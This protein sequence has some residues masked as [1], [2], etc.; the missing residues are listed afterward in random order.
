MIQANNS[1]SS[2]LTK[3]YHQT[4]AGEDEPEETKEAWSS[5]VFH[6]TLLF[7]VVDEGVETSACR[8]RIAI[9]GELWWPLLVS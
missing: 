3:V 9:S 8:H 6:E 1:L 5:S 7:V 4:R 2:K